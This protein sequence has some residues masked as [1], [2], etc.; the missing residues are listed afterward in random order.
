L[1]EHRQAP[2]ELANT[3]GEP[4]LL[5]TDHFDLAPGARPAVGSLL[6]DLDGV[7]PPRPGENPP[8]YVFLRPGN[9]MHASWD[10]TVIGR[11]RLSATSLALETNSRERAD[12]LRARVEA[13]CGERVRYRARQHTDPLSKRAPRR[14]GDAKPAPPPPE[15][16][17]VMLEFKRRHY[18]DWIDQPVP[19][20]GGQTPREAVRNARGRDAV[21]VLLKEIEN[22]EQRAGDGAAFDVS[23]T[24][25]ALGLA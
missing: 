4:L 7:E 15:V 10:N 11:A 5:T 13:A 14:A 19:A 20:L 22:H 1:D 3:D 2:S 23:E 24:R 8:F 12:A 25:R 21:D 17:Q 18:A 6:A 9:Q 16:Q